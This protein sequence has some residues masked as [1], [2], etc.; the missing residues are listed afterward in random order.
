MRHYATNNRFGKDF[1]WSHGARAS[2]S[3]PHGEREGEN[4][5][6]RPKAR[7][8]EASAASM[9][10]YQSFASAAVPPAI[11]PVDAEGYS[12]SKGRVFETIHL[13]APFLT[14]RDLLSLAAVARFTKGYL[15]T[16]T[17]VRLGEPPMLSSS[18]QHLRQLLIKLPNLQDLRASKGQTIFHLSWALEQYPLCQRLRC[19]DLSHARLWARGEGR[20]LAALDK[21][22]FPQRLILADT[23]VG[24]RGASGLANVL[25]R[26]ANT[27]QGCA[28]LSHL[29]L[30]ENN[31]RRSLF[32]LG[33]SL[34]SSCPMLTSLVLNSNPIGPAGLRLLLQGLGRH[35]EGLPAPRLRALVELSLI[36]TGLGEEG[37]GVLSEYLDRLPLIGL[38]RLRLN[39]NHLGNA[40]LEAISVA[41]QRG[42]CP[43]LLRLDL[44]G[45][46]VGSEGVQAFVA[47][48]EQGAVPCLEELNLSFNFISAEG[49]GAIGRV[50][51]SDDTA[52]LKRLRHIDVSRQSESAL[53]AF[54]LY[55]F[56]DMSHCN[57]PDVS[58]LTYTFGISIF[59][60][61]DVD[62]V[63][64]DT[65]Y[66]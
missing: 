16:I 36:E 26:R 15:A 13:I 50:V 40:G 19:L 7:S 41:L 23:G 51:V 2:R 49:L 54:A 22:A 28:E 55:R 25:K 17:E 61:K 5:M 53:T 45:N 24:D 37:A 33:A 27:A 66:R 39:G 56:K 57:S 43:D 29:D 1:G 11:H 59:D 58:K 42:G 9:A 38:R 14:T 52:A 35:E 65:A 32:D 30:S 4:V 20:L 21:C 31:L 12:H 6:W 3:N 18:K 47:A 63:A 48:C 46:H 34:A 64:L 44:A 60:Y 10:P 8:G 62:T